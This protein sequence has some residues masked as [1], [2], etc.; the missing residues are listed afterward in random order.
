MKKITIS[1]FIL[2]ISILLAACSPGAVLQSGKT[3]TSKLA[4]AATVQPAQ[5]VTY[6]RPVAQATPPVVSS[7]QVASLLSA[8]EGAL[9]AVYD[10][11]NPS[12]VN[13]RVVQQAT[14][15]DLNS[16]Q[17]P[18]PFP[19]IPGM[20]NIPN[21]QAPENQPF[22]EGLGS[23]FVWDQQGHI[24]TNNHVIDGADKIEITFSDGTIVPARAG[25]HRSRFRSGSLESGCRRRQAPSRSV[26]RFH[27]GQSRRACYRHWQPLRSGGHDDHRDYQRDW[28]HHAG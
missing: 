9:T 15:T 12:V 25:Q 8:Y 13:I 22:Q 21:D 5:P 3:D 24:V 23:G 6:A 11:V 26:H 28:P 7:S 14:Q 2:V 10:A 16:Q 27:P 1:S 20:P 19:S 4:P 17:L 18:F